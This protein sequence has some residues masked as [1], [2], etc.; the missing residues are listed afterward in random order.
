MGVG[1]AERVESAGEAIVTLG[2]VLEV[3]Q[4]R[5]RDRWL[6]IILLAGILG[7][8]L[9]HVLFAPYF[10]ILAPSGYSIGQRQLDL[11]VGDD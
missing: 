6:V 11:D 10:A 8:V 9:S 7:L 5:P 4:R 2:E 1:P 3:L